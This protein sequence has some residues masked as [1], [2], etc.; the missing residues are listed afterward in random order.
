MITPIKKM[1]RPL[2]YSRLHI[3]ALDLQNRLRYGPDAPRFGET[4]WL[5]PH[6]CTK[7]LA[8][9]ALVESS[10]IRTGEISGRVIEEPWPVEKARDIAS[11]AITRHCI[12]H[13]VKGVSWKET[14]EYE[15]MQ[16]LID[17]SP[18]GQVQGCRTMADVVKR[19]E[20]LDRIFEQAH[21]EGRLRRKEE[22]KP[23]HDWEL[24]E[25][26]MHIGP[27]G[28]LFKGGSGMHR[29]AIALIL[30]IPFPAEVG[31]VHVDAITHLPGYRKGSPGKEV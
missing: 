30:E 6:Q 25:I 29:F 17:N 2:K 11:I 23:E 22:I 20:N 19:C 3:W 10:G 18:S 1:A 13:W 16:K 24:R 15:R 8:T 12:E 7:A 21:R 28:E 27:K 4:F 14:G 26:V 31:F 5:F 9:T